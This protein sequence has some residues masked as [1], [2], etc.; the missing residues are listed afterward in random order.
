MEDTS[1]WNRGPA[2]AADAHELMAVG[3][4]GPHPAVWTTSGKARPQRRSAWTCHLGAWAGALQQVAINGL[5][6]VTLAQGD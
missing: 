3:S 5:H 4:D 1:D 6:V 2:V